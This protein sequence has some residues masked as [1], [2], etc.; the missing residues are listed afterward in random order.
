MS[1]LSATVELGPDLERRQDDSLAALGGNRRLISGITQPVRTRL[2]GRRVGLWFESL[3]RHRCTQW[4]HGAF[5]MS[6]DVFALLVKGF[7]T[8]SDLPLLV[9]FRCTGLHRHEGSLN[10]FRAPC[11]LL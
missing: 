7:G 2:Q 9:A 8:A 10:R 5:R 1:S 6:E 3:L 4:P 11:R